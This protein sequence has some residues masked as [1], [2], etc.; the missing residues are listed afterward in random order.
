LTLSALAIACA[1]AQADPGAEPA[2]LP[3]PAAAEAPEASPAPEEPPPEDDELSGYRARF[4]VLADRAIGTASVPVEFNW[5][6][7]PA[8]FAVQSSF[9]AELNNYDSVRVGGLARIPAGSLLVELGGNYVG[10]WQ[11]TSSR[12]LAFTPYRQPGR[13][14]RIEL[15][16]NLVFPIAEGVVTTF[17]KFL[18]SAQLVF[19]ADAGLRYSIMPQGYQGLRFGQIASST[20]NPALSE[21]ELANLDDLRLPAMQI[22][23]MR[24]GL[25]AG[26]GADLYFAPGLFFSPRVMLHLPIFAP[27][28]GSDLGAFAEMTLALGWAL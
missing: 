13:V 12:L 18:P 14:R 7:S 4:D 16:A 22:D 20:V 19:H 9:L 25:F 23:P 26:L 5:R 27:G 24:Y 17:P 8:M 28:T 3:P 2:D 15:D 6:R 21:D 11:T 1:F 10:V